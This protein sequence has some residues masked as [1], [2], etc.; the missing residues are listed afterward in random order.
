[1]TKIFNQFNT[2]TN[3]MSTQKATTPKPTS[4]KAAHVRIDELESFLKGIE[5]IEDDILESPA[6]APKKYLATGCVN[7]PTIGGIS[8][9]KNV[10][11]HELIRIEFEEVLDDNGTLRAPKREDVT[12]RLQEVADKDHPLNIGVVLQSVSLLPSSW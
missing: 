11:F 9:P 5:V 10:G 2:N 12:S 6:T 7:F 4:L 1:V 8:L 3:T